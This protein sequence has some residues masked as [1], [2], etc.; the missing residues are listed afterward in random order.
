MLEPPRIVA[1]NP[2]QDRLTKAKKLFDEGYEVK[3]FDNVP[4]MKYDML[5]WN[6]NKR[7]PKTGQIDAMVIEIGWE[8]LQ[9]FMGSEQFNVLWKQLA[10][11]HNAV[12]RMMLDKITSTNQGGQAT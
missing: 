11:A 8:E 10:D 7:D 6:R 4:R 9:Q 5:F 2:I 1:D 3:I 12:V